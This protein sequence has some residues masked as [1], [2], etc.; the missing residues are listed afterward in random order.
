MCLYRTDAAAIHIVSIYQD[1]LFGVSLHS[2]ETPVNTG[3]QMDTDVDNMSRT[4]SAHPE[5][6]LPEVSTCSL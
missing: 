6:L 1:P 5:A 2:P 3:F 4:D